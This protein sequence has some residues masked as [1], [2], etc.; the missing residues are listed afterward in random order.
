M[1]PPGAAPNI[2]NNA[3][4]PPRG[5][6]GA[7]SC[8]EAEMGAVDPSKGQQISTDE[9]GIFSSAEVP[10]LVPSQVSS[11]SPMTEDP[12]REEGAM[13]PRAAAQAKV[14]CGLDADRD[15]AS[16]TLQSRFHR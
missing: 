3:K 10:M 6:G 9:V 13:A 11:A 15:G 2:A 4:H 12:S 16:T 5:F 7:V 1:K 14:L 8:T